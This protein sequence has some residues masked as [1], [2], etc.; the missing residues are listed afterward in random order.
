[1]SKLL[2]FFRTLIPTIE[3]RQVLDEQYLAEAVDICDLERRMR[4]LDRRSRDA[5]PD[6][7]FG[8]GSR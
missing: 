5:S 7:T 3:S 2:Q 1:M 6:L 4:E 8:L